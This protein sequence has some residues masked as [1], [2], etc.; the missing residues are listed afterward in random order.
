MR[1]AANDSSYDGI[2]AA[3]EEL[4]IPID[5]HP[6][7]TSAAVRELI[8]PACPKAPAES[9][10]TQ[11]EGA[12]GVRVAELIAIPVRATCLCVF[13]SRPRHSVIATQRAP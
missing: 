3:A 10:A 13:A 11:A 12:F 7:S 5:I 6:H 2:L 1:Q 8:S 4:D 9:C